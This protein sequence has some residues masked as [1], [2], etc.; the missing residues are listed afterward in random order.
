M[1]FVRLNKPPVDKIRK[2]RAK[3]FRENVDDDPERENFG[4]RILSGSYHGHNISLVED[5]SIC[6][7]KRE[8]YMRV[9]SR[10]IPKEIY[11]TAIH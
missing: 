4:L 7:T 10:G 9:L 11:Q 2:H 5:T 1:E 3:D 8:G 6:S